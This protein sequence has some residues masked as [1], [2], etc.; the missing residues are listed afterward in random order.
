MYEGIGH[1]K[2]PASHIPYDTKD[3]QLARYARDLT[4]RVIAE[5]TKL[6]VKFTKVY[7]VKVLEENAKKCRKENEGLT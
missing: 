6:L 5:Y 7:D 3:P 2:P 1:W 4:T